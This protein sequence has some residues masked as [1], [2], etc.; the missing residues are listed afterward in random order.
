MPRKVL[1]IMTAATVTLLFSTAMSR[2]VAQ[3]PRRIKIIVARFSYTPDEIQLKKDESVVLVLRSVDVTHGL[4][5]PELHIKAE[6]KKGKETEIA[7]TPQTA[8]Q[9]VG[10]CAY[11]CGQGHAAMMLQISV[12]E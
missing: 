2:S 7:L 6:I 10:K 11:F 9:F 1:W 8:G 4:S 12:K 5:V 3:T